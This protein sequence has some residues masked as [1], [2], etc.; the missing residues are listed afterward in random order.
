VDGLR[1]VV[2]AGDA[3]EL[4]PGES[5]TLPARLY[6]EFWGAG[7]SVL[8]GEVSMVNDDRTDNRFYEPVR[9]F[10]DMEEDEPPLNL[11]VAD[12]AKNVEYAK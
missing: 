8:A 11:L 1:R 9:R 12:Y 2:K 7:S 4:S 5:I 6:H 3:V 10:P